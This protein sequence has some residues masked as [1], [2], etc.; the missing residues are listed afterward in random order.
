MR[1]FLRR[2]CLMILICSAFLHT[3]SAQSL[4]DWQQATGADR[5]D[6]RSSFS[7]LSFHG[8]IWILG[9]GRENDLWNSPDG[10]EW[11]KVQTLSDWHPNQHSCSIVFDGRMWVFGG[12]KTIDGHV[13]ITNEVWSSSDGIG[14]SQTK[15][16]SP[17]KKRGDTAATQFLGKIWLLGGQAGSNAFGDVWSSTDGEN[18]EQI[19]AMAPWGGRYNHSVLVHH[20]KIWVIAGYSKPDPGGNCDDIWSS[21]NGRDWERVI[22]SLP[23]GKRTGM[24]VASEGDYIWV[25][26]GYAGGLT[27]NKSYNDVW[28]SEDGRTWKRMEASAPWS[29]RC[30]HASLGFKGNLWIIGGETLPQKKFGRQDL[31]NDAWNVPIR[32]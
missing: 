26:G 32:N 12:I 29:A 13:Q 16:V 10:K 11:T 5:W 30:G 8:R 15:S 28:S 20:D 19:S 2:L 21:S 31:W 24:G 18:W 23:W 3:V 14:W 7:V 17:W 4:G 9:G 1:D 22:S 25:S 6:P 27:Q